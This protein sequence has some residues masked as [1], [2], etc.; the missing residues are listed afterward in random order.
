VIRDQIERARIY[1][2]TARREGLQGTVLVRF[3]VGSDG[4]VTAVEIARSS[5]HELLDQASA[6]TVR[7]AAPYPAF[8]GWIRIPLAYRLDR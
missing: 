8:P 3:R 1:P 6:D 7:R 4:A 2:D 5:G